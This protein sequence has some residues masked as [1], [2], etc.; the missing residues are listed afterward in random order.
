MKKNSQEERD[1]GKRSGLRV[2]RANIGAMVLPED[3]LEGVD[4]IRHAIDSGM[5]Y[6]D[7]SRGYGESEHV[8]ATALKD[9][10]REKVVLSTKWAP[11]IK[12]VSESDDTSA[13]CVRRRIDESMQRLQV[14]YLDFY[15]IWNICTREVWDQA[16]A[17]GGMV[18]GILKAKKEGLVRHIGFTSHDSP[19]NLLDYIKVADWCEVLLVGFNLLNQRYV[20]V[21]EA[22]HKK[23]I[24]TLV[25]NPL[26]GGRFAQVNPILQGLVKEVG[27]VSLPDL[28]I[29]YVLA[30]P[31]VDTVL[32]GMKKISDVDDTLASANREPLTAEQLEKIDKFI[33]TLSRKNVGFCTDCKYCMPCPHGINISAIMNL[34]Y[35]DRFWN[36]K[37][38]ARFGYKWIGDK[39]ADACVQCGECEAK[40]TQKLNITEEMKYAA[41]EYSE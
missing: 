30:N 22:A 20:P 14:D 29:R 1:L 2:P 3:N 41:K 8:L 16:T 19:E 27:A 6:I 34:I 13:D 21:L 39:K 17:K 25:M 7:T 38:Y 18:E 31:N 35:E 26:G 5:R 37:K 24:G 33:S 32:C 40:C 11:W 10:Y 23:G 12:K 15:Q 36:M 9:G 28:A 4:I